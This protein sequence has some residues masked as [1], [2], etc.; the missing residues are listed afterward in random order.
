MILEVVFNSHNGGPDVTAAQSYLT[1]AFSNIG[2]DHGPGRF[3]D[4]G[5]FKQFQFDLPDGYDVGA[6]SRGLTTAL[7]NSNLRATKPTA[8]IGG[9]TTLT[10]RPAR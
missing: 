4:L 1:K 3:K 9:I 8:F 7:E 5:S 6:F 2:Q 10:V